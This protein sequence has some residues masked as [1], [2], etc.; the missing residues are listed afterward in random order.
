MYIHYTKNKTKVKKLLD[1]FSG[2]CYHH[3]METQ[4]LLTQPL[5]IQKTLINKVPDLI[6]D[7]QINENTFKALV[8]QS[9]LSFDTGDRLLK[10][11]TNFSIRT[12][13]TLADQLGVRISQIIDME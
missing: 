1:R 12:L 5:G 2:I 9:G 6:K 4:K 7:L 10:G 11:E 13:A 3:A 8:I